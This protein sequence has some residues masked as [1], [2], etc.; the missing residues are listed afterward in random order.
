MTEW[1]PSLT[2]LVNAGLLQQYAETHPS[3][4]WAKLLSGGNLMDTVHGGACAD[5]GSCFMRVAKEG[6]DTIDMAIC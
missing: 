5:P 3:M 6:R 2:E 1:C 4:Y